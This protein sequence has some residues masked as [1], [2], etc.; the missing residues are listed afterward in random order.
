MDG[1]KRLEEMLKGQK[2]KY[3]N[4]IVNHLI[5]HK[6]MNIYFLNEEKNLK[7]MSEYIKKNARKKAS[8]SVAVIEDTK[9]FQW[10]E[11]YF[12][13]SNKELGISESKLEKRKSEKTSKV[14]TKDDGF[15]PIFSCEGNEKDKKFGSIFDCEESVK[16]EETIEQISLF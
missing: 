1:I 5:Q 4:I 6:E 2:D 11:E 9:V 12:I 8:G 3:L 10:A 15:G 16:N 13:K 7:D 14:T